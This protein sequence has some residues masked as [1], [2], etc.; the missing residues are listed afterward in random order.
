MARTNSSKG[1][2]PEIQSKNPKKLSR[3]QKIRKRCRRAMLKSNSMVGFDT[4]KRAT[5]CVL[6]NHSKNLIRLAKAEKTP[7]MNNS[8][9]K[10]NTTYVSGFDKLKTLNVDGKYRIEITKDAILFLRG[11]LYKRLTLILKLI[12]QMMEGEQRFAPRECDVIKLKQL[13]IF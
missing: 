6:A 8:D 1:G 11:M 3:R 13:K 7:N 9:S 10:L 5:S 4:I 2:E 12:F